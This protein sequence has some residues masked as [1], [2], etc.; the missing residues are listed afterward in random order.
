LPRFSIV[1]PAY[2]AEATLAETLDAVLAQTFEDWECVIVNDGSTDSTLALASSYASR[3]S[4]FRVL[5]QENQ[6]TGGAYNTGVSNAGGEFIVICS[7]DDI[8]LPEHLEAMS[9]LVDAAPD[10]EIYTC[11]GYFWH[12][13]GSK[14][15]VH[16][17]VELV[18]MES[19]TLADVIRWCFYGVGAVYR[20]EIFDTVG[21]YRVGVFGEDYD[22]WMRAMASG[23]RHKFTPKI[24]SMHRVSPTQKSANVERAY[25]SDIRLVSELRRDF[26]LSEDEL[27]A[28][29]DCISTRERYIPLLK[30]APVEVPLN[31]REKTAKL[32]A[33][34]IG[35][36]RE[37]RLRMRIRSLLGKS[38]P[39]SGSPNR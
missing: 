32:V 10:Y 18:N 15:P 20:H 35:E 21:G 36:D 22:F 28:V 37:Y 26:D 24:L 13:D 17:A 25:R 33:R 11:S 38:D 30:E 14:V 12:P 19:V 23:A 5:T 39:G 27:A 2:N 3:D 6:G 1:V 8:L 34:V 16:D 4:R 7:A 29:D 9:E 31:S